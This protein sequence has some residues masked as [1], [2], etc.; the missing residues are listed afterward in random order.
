MQIDIVVV[1]RNNG[2]FLI[3]LKYFKIGWCTKYISKLYFPRKSRTVD[4]GS[5][6]HINRIASVKAGY[7]LYR[8]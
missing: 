1:K 8:K 2:V 6:L 7:M 3:K 4:L 5:F